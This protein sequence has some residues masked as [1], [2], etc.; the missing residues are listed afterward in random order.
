VKR[1]AGGVRFAAGVALALSLASGHAA[2]HENGAAR[3]TVFLA[4]S[5]RFRI[6]A[7][8]DPTHLPPDG[9]AIF[10]RDLSLEF[11]GVR[12]VPRLTPDSDAPAQKPF[13]LRFEGEIPPGAAHVTLREESAMG[14]MLVE[15]RN[16]GVDPPERQW[17]RGGRNAG[18]FVVAAAP[19]I[20]GIAETSS[21]YLALGFRHIVPDGVDHIFFVLGLFL[22]SRK[23]KPLLMQVTAFTL[24][25]STTLGLAMLGVVSLPSS[26]VE[27]AIALS[28]AFVACENVFRTETSRARIAI[29]FGFGLLHGLGFAGALREIGL[30][31]SRFVPALI[32][33]NLGVEAGQLT[34]LAVAFALVGAWFSRRA[35][36]RS[37]VAVPASLAIACVGLYWTWV[38]L[39]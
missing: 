30:P 2:A 15:A 12:C 24:A 1:L 31:R 17:T 8:L 33:F 28:I 7:R 34:V 37:R 9:A 39:P 38:R 11:D 4:K 19:P 5:G 21:R 22:A 3:V 27:P 20:P 16:E 18:P 25:H 35:W 26:I 29:V 10:A 23:L 14:E 13:T 36:Y 32:S 6:E